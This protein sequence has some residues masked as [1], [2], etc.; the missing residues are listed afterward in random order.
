MNQ[1]ATTHDKRSGSSSS[2]SSSGGSRRTTGSSNNNWSS[3]SSLS[4]REISFIHC[5]GRDLKTAREWCVRYKITKDVSDINQAWQLYYK[6]FKDIQKQLPQLKIVHLRSSSPWLLNA[7]DLELTIPG[8]NVQKNDIGTASVHIRKFSPSMTVLVSKQRPRRMK[9]TGS[10]GQEYTFLLKG[11]EDLRQDE[12][13]M[14]LF[15]LVNA[16][17]KSGECSSIFVFFVSSLSL[18]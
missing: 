14:Q 11:H 4:T 9:L 10:D 16:L 3:S 15:G 12:R 5:F 18:A 8:E 13:V 7:R 17:L 6:V 2:S 1:H